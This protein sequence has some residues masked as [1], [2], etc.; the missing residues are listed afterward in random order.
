MRMSVEH[1]GMCLLDVAVDIRH[2]AMLGWLLPRVTSLSSFAA[3]VY[4]VFE[5]VIQQ[6]WSEG[7]VLLLRYCLTDLPDTDSSHTN[8]ASHSA[9]R[10]H[11]VNEEDDDGGD[12]GVCGSALLSCVLLGY[13]DSFALF[14]NDHQA[15]SAKQRERGDVTTAERKHAITTATS[16][17]RNGIEPALASAVCI[18]SSRAVVQLSVHDIPAA[19]ERTKLGSGSF[20]QVYRGR[21]QSGREAAFKVCMCV[22]V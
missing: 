9:Q 18:S 1:K 3:R 17:D 4:K 7:F 12:V 2:T 13:G 16:M 8:D 6:G 19:E 15:I 10:H 21:L 20:G 11:R 14:D 5:A 22:C